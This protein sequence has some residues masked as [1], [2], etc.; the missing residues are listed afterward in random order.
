MLTSILFFDSA[1]VFLQLSV[2]QYLACFSKGASG[3]A[4]L[5]EDRKRLY[6]FS[7]LNETMTRP[8]HHK[9]Q[10]NSPQASISC[11]PQSMSRR[12]S[13]GRHTDRNQ[14]YSAK[15]QKQSWSTEILVV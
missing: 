5:P 4:G 10:F 11:K 2:S 7:E 9:I 15:L 12:C 14:G 13:F 6:L 8:F 1:F 3:I